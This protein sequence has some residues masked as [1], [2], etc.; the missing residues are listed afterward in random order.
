MKMMVDIAHDFLMSVITPQS[1]AVDFTMG[2]GFDTLFLAQK[3]KFVYAFDIQPQALA[4]TRERL[5]KAEVKNVQLILDGHQNCA[6]YLPYFDI[7][8]FNLGYLPGASHQLTTEVET[9]KKAVKTALDLLKIGGR[10]VIVV[11]PGHE[12]G[13]VESEYLD[14]FSQALDA[15]DYHAATFKMTNKRLSPYL[16][17]I[18]KVA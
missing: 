1:I 2:K 12:K 6:S 18:D 3:A 11:Y 14:R 16:I 7:G 13:A 17:I 8:I 4:L 5:D 10:L 9:T 15:H